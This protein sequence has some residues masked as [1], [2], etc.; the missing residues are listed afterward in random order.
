MPTFKPPGRTA[1]DGAPVRQ[2]AT[3]LCPIAEAAE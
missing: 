1:T 3:P 2:T